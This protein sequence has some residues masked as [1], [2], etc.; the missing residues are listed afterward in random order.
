MA[1]VP[2]IVGGPARLLALVL[3]QADADLVDGVE[4]GKKGAQVGSWRMKILALRE[5]CFYSSR[6]EEIE[7]TSLRFRRNLCGRVA[8]EN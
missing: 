1:G 2:L 4:A 7:V 6:G 3:D 5:G 8:K